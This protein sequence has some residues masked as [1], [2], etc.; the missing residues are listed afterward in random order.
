MGKMLR[1]S[2]GQNQVVS[3]VRKGLVGLHSGHGAYFK[4]AGWGGIGI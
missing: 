4:K 1:P 3:S 2:R